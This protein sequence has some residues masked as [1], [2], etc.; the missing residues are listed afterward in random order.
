MTKPPLLMDEQFVL[1]SDE[2]GQVADFKTIFGNDRPVEIEIGCGRGTLMVHL[3]QTKPDHN[4]LGIEWASKFYRYTVDRI[5]RWNL[6]NV[7]MLRTDAR[8]FVM[9]QLPPQSVSVFHVYFPDPWPKKRHHKRR[10]FIPDFC[11][12][13]SRVLMPGGKIYAASDHE[14]YFQQ[15]ETNLSAIPNFVPCE[16]DSPAGNEVLSNYEAKFVKEGRS[17]YRVAVKKI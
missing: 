8:E 2:I 6:T 5:R 14:E 3:A 4:F 1:P 12:V 15:I 9:R 17:I 10:L 11:Q 13:L 7:K 16:F